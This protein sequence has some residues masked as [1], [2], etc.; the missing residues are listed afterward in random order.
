[1]K[2]KIS[3][4]KFEKT[5]CESQQGVFQFLLVFC[6]VAPAGCK[7]QAVARKKLTENE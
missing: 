6:F 3:Q 7:A 1:M 4:K 2:E 5:L